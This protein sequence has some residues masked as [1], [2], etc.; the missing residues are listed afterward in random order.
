MTSHPVL[1]STTS[2]TQIIDSYAQSLLNKY[3]QQD[4][5][6][7]LGSYV[8]AV[9]RQNATE[10]ITTLPELDSLLELLQEHATIHN[11]QD[12]MHCLTLIA[13]AVYTGQV[14][15]E[16]TDTIHNL[17]PQDLW[18]DL[19]ETQ[20]HEDDDQRMLL[21]QQHQQQYLQNLHPD[22]SFAAAETALQ[23]AQGDL[24]IAQFLINTARQ[25]PPVCRHL[26]K[27]GC[28]RADCT[29][30]HDIDNHTC[31]F[32]MTGRC[33]HGKECRFLHGFSEL[34][35]EQ[36]YQQQPE[37]P[38][39]QYDAHQPELKL[40]TQSWASTT[41]PT[42]A[43]FARVA[44][45]GYVPKQSFSGASSDKKESSL[46]TVK[47]PQDLWNP[48]ENRDAAVFAVVDPVQRYE[49]LAQS[50]PRDDVIDLHFQSTKTFPAVLER[51]LPE[52]L[53]SYEEV[54][55]VTGTGH[56]VGNKTHQKSGGALERA[57]VDWLVD[58]GYEFYRGKDRNG[59]GGAV[60]VKR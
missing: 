52:K 27:D 17:I 9:L 40:A 59:N 57:V 32:W 23:L 51:I 1:R 45:Q 15:Y 48:H 35:L 18:G 11:T 50:V 24:H 53:Q 58:Y 6:E 36:W 30:S 21:A 2:N 47:I 41:A 22:I 29:F 44:S 39:Y 13:K 54:W 38:Q 8:T 34:G 56:H 37:P 14:P 33:K 46:T 43:S 42:T 16:E 10:D 19:G 3:A 20:Q 26:L 5:E 55:I 49:L 25:A 4:T 28:Y 7:S 60:L 12:A 31:V